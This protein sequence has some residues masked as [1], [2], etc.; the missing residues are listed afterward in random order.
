MV[1]LVTQVYF[2]LNLLVNLYSQN[3]T[4]FDNRREQLSLF[5]KRLLLGSFQ[6]L[7]LLEQFD[8][9]LHLI[10]DPLFVPLV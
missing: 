3:S 1:S 8:P 2:L 9:M 5:L 4:R 7:Q 10:D 6:S